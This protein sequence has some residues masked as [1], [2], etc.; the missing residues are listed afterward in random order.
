M[1]DRGKQFWECNEGSRRDPKSQEIS[2]IMTAR[3]MFD[4]LGPNPIACVALA[5]VPFPYDHACNKALSGEVLLTSR[6][7]VNNYLREHVPKNSYCR[8]TL[9]VCGFITRCA[10]RGSPAMLGSPF[11][12]DNRCRHADRIL[13]LVLVCLLRQ[14]IPL[15]ILHTHSS[16]PR[17]FIPRVLP[18]VISW[19]KSV[20]GTF[21]DT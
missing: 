16:P 20:V 10:S 3:S 6:R 19:S 21:N 11:P 7:Q 14:Y 8:E 17:S 18:I 4:L 2:W 9:R 13:W 12:I 15:G 5:A 1:D